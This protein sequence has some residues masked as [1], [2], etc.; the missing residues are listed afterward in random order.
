MYEVNSK[1][2][3]QYYQIELASFYFL[4]SNDEVKPSSR[5]L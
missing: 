3:A 4:V 5:S 1:F 2:L